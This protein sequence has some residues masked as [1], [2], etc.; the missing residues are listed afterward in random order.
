MCEGD[1]HHLHTDQ[2]EQH[3]I[4]DF[5]QQRPEEVDSQTHQHA[6]VQM[7]MTYNGGTPADTGS[8]AARPC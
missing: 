1:H 7:Q 5:V 3:R 2:D 8:P 6:F 4:E